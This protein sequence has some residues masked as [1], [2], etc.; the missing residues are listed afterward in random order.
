MFTWRAE[1]PGLTTPGIKFV[2]SAPEI[3][4][5]SSRENKHNRKYR[6]RMKTEAE[7]SFGYTHAVLWQIHSYIHCDVYF[8]P[9]A[10]RTLEEILAHRAFLSRRMEHMFQAVDRNTSRGVHWNVCEQF[11]ITCPLNRNHMT[12]D[13]AESEPAEVRDYYTHWLYM[14]LRRWYTNAYKNMPTDSIWS[15][16]FAWIP[17]KFVVKTVPACAHT[18]R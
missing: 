17:K 2:N 1:T 3:Q 10:N 8:R 11:F 9:R 4:S 13:S 16:Q 7:S 6:H 14:D 15:V 12:K 18:V 5:V